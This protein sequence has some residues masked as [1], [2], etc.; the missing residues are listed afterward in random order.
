MKKINLK[1]S[2]ILNRKKLNLK[3][4]FLFTFAV[5]VNINFFAKELRLPKNNSTF[6]KEAALS[7]L[8]LSTA[9]TE[10]NTAAILSSY[11]F[12]ILKQKNYENSSNQ[13]K[14][15]A[16]YSLSKGSIQIEEKKSS[17]YILIVRGTD[18]NE[19]YSNFDFAPS[20]S[21]DTH[22]AANFLF[23][24]EEI[25]LDLKNIIT[26]KNAKIILAGHSRGGAVVN[27][28]ALLLNE[29]Y[30]PKNIYAYTFASPGTIKNI[31]SLV[32]YN[33]FNFINPTDLVPKMPL[34]AWGFFRAGKDIILDD[35]SENFCLEKMDQAVSSI[36]ELAPSLSSY[37]NDRHSLT[38]KSF[39]EDGMT[40]Y[41]LVMAFSTQLSKLS[42]N[43]STLFSD[44]LEENLLDSFSLEKSTTENS[45]SDFSFPQVELNSDFAK[46]FSYFSLLA[47]DG[48]KGAKNLLAEHMPATYREKI[49]RM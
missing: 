27:L 32:D 26:D 23:C 42:S 46:I 15:S 47:K 44:G 2:G 30:N 5:F 21:D 38:S 10:K 20:A 41:E 45:A 29:Y 7:L 31:S 22:F 8:E 3:R 12:K 28:L 43:N 49:L 35:Q 19:W 6:T 36:W 1:G 17:A 11:D 16:A 9:H 34:A 4:I 25:F 48:G 33:I 13:I 37:Y 39:S 18:G 24:A 14:H 40:C